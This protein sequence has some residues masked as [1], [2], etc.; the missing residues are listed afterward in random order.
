MG[1]ILITNW[2][3]S[4]RPLSIKKGITDGLEIKF[5]IE[6]EV[7]VVI[8]KGVGGVSR[9]RAVNASG[10]YTKQEITRKNSN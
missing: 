5:P 3:T 9:L 6:F 10:K 1:K 2:D 7:A 8:Q 4:P